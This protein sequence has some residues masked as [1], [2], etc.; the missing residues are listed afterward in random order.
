MKSMPKT[1]FGDILVQYAYQFNTLKYS[2]NPKLEIYKKLEAIFLNKENEIVESMELSSLANLS[3]VCVQQLMSLEIM[4]QIKDFSLD[5][6]KQKHDRE[7]EPHDVDPL[8]LLIGSLNVSGSLSPQMLAVLVERFSKSLQSQYLSIE[9][10]AK[11]YI[12]LSRVQKIYV[13]SSE[14]AAF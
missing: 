5:I 3:I 7:L 6:L 2:P 11:L 13:E 8:C 12:S 10:C 9:K 1:Q 14:S 4:G